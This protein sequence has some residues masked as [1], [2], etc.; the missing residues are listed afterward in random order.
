MIVSTLFIENPKET[1]SPT[2]LFL[3]Q[4]FKEINL[5][6]CTEIFRLKDPCILR[7]SRGAKTRF[8]LSQ[9]SLQ[10]ALYYSNRKTIQM[11]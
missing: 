2:S 9:G 7:V 10:L 11:I 1:K 5:D 6:V 8:D 4:N 3:I